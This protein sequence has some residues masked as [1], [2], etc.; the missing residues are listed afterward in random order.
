MNKANKFFPD[1][2]ERGVRLVQEH[3]DEYPELCAAVEP[4]EPKMAVCP[5]SC[6]NGLSAKK[7]MAVNATA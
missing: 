2:R 7:S 1:I 3:R 6:L 5:R 4:I